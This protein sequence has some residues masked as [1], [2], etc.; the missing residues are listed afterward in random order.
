MPSLI[1]DDPSVLLTTAGMQQFKPYFLGKADPIK[2]FGSKNTA[3]IQKSFRT[4]DIDLVGDESH[5][6]FFEMLGNFSFGGYFKK[7]AIEYGY[8]FIVKEL[9]LEIHYVTVFGGDR[10]VGADEESVKIWQSLGV[11]D[12]RKGSREDNFWGPTGSEGPCGPTTEIYVRGV[13]VWNLVFNEYY[14]HPGGKLEKLRTPGVDTGMGLERLVMVVQ[15]MPTIFET[16]LFKPIFNFLDQ[17]LSKPR[18]EWS[19]RIIADHIRGIVFLIVD[20]VRPSNKDQGYILRRLMRRAMPHLLEFQL[21][22]P[23]VVGEKNDHAFKMRGLELVADCV[24]REY[25]KIKDYKYLSDRRE[26][27]LKVIR[28]ENDSFDRVYE[29]GSKVLEKII[30]KAVS[31]GTFV[32]SGKDIFDLV[33]SHGFSIE[34]IKDKARKIHGLKLELDVFDEEFKKHQEVSRAGL[35][36]KFG[37][38]GLI[39]NTGELK[40]GDEAELKKVTRL[41]TATHLLQW[42]LREVLGKEVK[43]AGSDITPER[44][45]FDFTFPRKLTPEETKKVEELV[46]QKIMENLPVSFKEM[47]RLEAEKTGALYFFKEKYPDKVKVYYIGK[48][49]ES[50]V[51]K[52]FCGGPHVDHTSKIG[53]FKIDP[54]APR[55]LCFFSLRLL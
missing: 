37:G 8:E 16:D 54:R 43:Q 42:A 22:D 38:H 13:E 44:T 5:L 49:L 14:C 34:W 27:I 53:E 3:S 55:P 7:E 1:P 17:R 15:N 20:G 4:S 11:K 21:W 23:V 40:A 52:E 10:E 51:S 18:P 9:G 6:T 46:N 2:D 12:I 28:E 45:R 19:K 48:S 32:I 36:K 26:E 41:H 39:L 33:T 24:I 31:D 47:P 35:E 50:A 30:N 25:S 29:N